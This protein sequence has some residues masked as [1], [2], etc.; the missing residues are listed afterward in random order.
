METLLAGLR[1]IPGIDALRASTLAAR[2]QAYWIF[3]TGAGFAI[4]LS[5]ALGF[6]VGTVIVGQTIYS[7][8]IDRLKEFGTLKAIGAANRDLYRLI[9]SQ[10]LIYAAAGYVLGMGAS[11]GVARLSTTL[12]SP[13]TVSPALIAGMLFVTVA[14]CLLASFLSV[15]RITR[16]EPAM[17]FKA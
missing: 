11:A 1:E 12:G 16:L 9:F 17:V 7:S 15:A 5:T 2:S 6:V 4:G 8:T 14:M 10:A 13:V 3:H